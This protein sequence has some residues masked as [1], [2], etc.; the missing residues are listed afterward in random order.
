[1]GISPEEIDRRVKEAYDTGILEGTLLAKEAN[2][3]SSTITGWKMAG[4]QILC[5]VLFIVAA[6]STFS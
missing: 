1:M 4:M 3:R 2:E 5:A 6:F